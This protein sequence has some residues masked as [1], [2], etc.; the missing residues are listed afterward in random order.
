MGFGQLDSSAIGFAGLDLVT[1]SNVRPMFWFM[2]RLKLFDYQNC[3]LKERQFH[4]A[5]FVFL[6]GF[7]P[8]ML[9]ELRDFHIGSGSEPRNKRGGAND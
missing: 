7:A 6:M 3:T 9:P 8:D 1:I 4:N 2:K 5:S